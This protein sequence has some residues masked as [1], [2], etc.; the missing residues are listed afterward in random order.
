ML[1]TER[2]NGFG[3]TMAGGECG[4]KLI[5]AN[6]LTHKLYIF[7]NFIMIHTILPGHISIGMKRM[8]LFFL[9]FPLTHRPERILIF[10]LC[11]GRI[12]LLPMENKVPQPYG[13]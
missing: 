8:V 6:S 4:G 1:P 9:L 10:H 7:N 2:V 13:N 3:L 11:R 12:T 5:E